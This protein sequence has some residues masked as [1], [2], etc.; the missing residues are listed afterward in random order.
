MCNVSAGII[1]LLETE[2]YPEFLSTFKLKTA[3]YVQ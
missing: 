1:V 3:I 2:K